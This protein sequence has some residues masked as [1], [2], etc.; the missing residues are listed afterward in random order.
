MTVTARIACLFLIGFPA[1][2]FAYD[3]S[4]YKTDFWAGEY[5]EGFTLKQDVTTNIRKKLDR[6][7]PRDVTCTLK[8]GET[9]HPWNDERVKASKLEFVSYVKKVPYEI[10]G[11]ATLTLMNEKSEKD[12]ILNFERDDEWTYLTYYGEGAFR[13]EFKGVVYTADQSLFDVSREKGVDGANSNHELF[14][15]MKLTCANGTTGWLLYEDVHNQPGYQRPEF[16]EYG[17]AVDVR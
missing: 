14:E 15:W 6:D 7:A 4:W 16:P 13:M 5:P 12:V 1:A 8:E 10:K 9:Y 17:K 2:A 11:D 3:A